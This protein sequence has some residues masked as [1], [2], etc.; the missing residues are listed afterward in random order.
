[1]ARP[2]INRS[3]TLTVRLLQVRRHFNSCTTCKGSIKAKDFDRLCDVAKDDLLFVASRWDSN[4]A[5]RLAVRRNGNE[6]QFLCPDPN[7]H[8][9]AYAA[10]AEPVTVTG[11]MESLF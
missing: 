8:G 11:V 5:G 2:N 3:T 6:L 1:M 9:P 10:T 4:I 7:A